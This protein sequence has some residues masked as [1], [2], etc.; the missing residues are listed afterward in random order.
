M[1]IAVACERNI[2]SEHF[3]HC[4][5]FDIYE[6]ENK[7]ILKKEY[8]QNPGHRLGYLPVFLKELNVDIII[9]GG[10]GSTAQEL[11]GQNNIEVIVGTLG[12]SDEVVQKYINGEIT[13]TGSI[14]TE[15]TPESHC[16]GQINE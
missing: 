4:E 14:C 10:M 11:F 12:L 16:N 1:K 8:I 13:S 15:H 2:V 6:V 7:N 9:S 5:G 3:G